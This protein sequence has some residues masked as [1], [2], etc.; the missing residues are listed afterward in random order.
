[1]DRPCSIGV[2]LN[3]LKMQSVM[4][5]TIRRSPNGKKPYSYRD[6]SAT[7]RPPVNKL[8]TM[9]A[10]TYIRRGEGSKGGAID[11]NH[12]HFDEDDKF[13]ISLRALKP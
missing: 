12:G 7:V 5:R 2:S 13:G 6:L 4:A 8:C 3:A 11:P 1:M 9:R 10:P